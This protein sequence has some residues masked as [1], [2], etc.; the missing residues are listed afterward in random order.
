MDTHPDDIQQLV[1]LEE[2]AKARLHHDEQPA[3]WSPKETAITS[4][5]KAPQSP[6]LQMVNIHTI[7]EEHRDVWVSMKS[8]ANSIGVRGTLML[9]Y[10]LYL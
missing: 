1:K 7:H 5:A 3:L 6:P 10:C 2:Y 8:M 4:K 9:I